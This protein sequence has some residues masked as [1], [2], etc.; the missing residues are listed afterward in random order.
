MRVGIVGRRGNIEYGAIVSDPLSPINTTLHNIITAL[1]GAG[2]VVYTDADTWITYPYIRD[3]KIE[4]Y[5]S[6][7]AIEIQEKVEVF[8][9]VGGD[10]TVLDVARQVAGSGKPI[11]GVNQGR[12]G[13]ITDI[14]ADIAPKIILE[15]LNMRF[16]NPSV[17]VE[18][19]HLLSLSKEGKD[20]GI[21]LN[22]VTISKM[23]GRMIEYKVHIGK[24]GNLQFAY[25]ARADGLIVAT[26]TG[27]TAYALAAGGSI[28]NPTS[29]VIQIIPM[30]P[31]TISYSPLIIDDSYSVYFELVSG[32]AEAWIDGQGPHYIQQGYQGG[33]LISQADKK[34]TL[35]HPKT[36][37][38]SY[39]YWNTL[40]QKLNWHL[41]PG[42][43]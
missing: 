26:P 39:D 28:I 10:G 4:K 29:R 32:N 19:R 9:V 24:A 36:Q 25:K 3:L 1:I 30:F 35:W 8:V 21:A 38:V 23:G 20:L 6:L 37:D 2:H 18:V 13:F 42:T 31:Q 15:M 7:T 40:R 41:E 27:S 22:E 5:E 12:L 33:V 16:S 34:I 43:K 17:V 11:I 14:P